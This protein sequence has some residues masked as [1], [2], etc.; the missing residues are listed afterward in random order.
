M[1]NSW[2]K[3]LII[4]ILKKTEELDNLNNWRPISLVNC[5]AK[6]FMKVI[7]NRLNLICDNIIPSHQQGFIRNRSITDTALDIITTMR[8]QKDSSKQHWM[9]FVD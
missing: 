4:L 9:L 8:N 1:P 7:A 6:I 3:N 5:D 2:C